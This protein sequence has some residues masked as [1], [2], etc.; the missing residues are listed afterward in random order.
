MVKS[1]QE[2]MD[3]ALRLAAEID[4]IFLAADHWNRGHP[5]E[6]IEIDPDG[7]LRAAGVEARRVFASLSTPPTGLEV[8]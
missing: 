1:R 2:L 6:P 3:E 5:Y 4:Q 8:N 7:A